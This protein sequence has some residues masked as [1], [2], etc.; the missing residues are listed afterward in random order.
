MWCWF[1][2][3][4]AQQR[5]ASWI[6]LKISSSQSTLSYF[7]PRLEQQHFIAAILDLSKSQVGLEE[8]YK[9]K[10]G[11]HVLWGNVD[12][13]SAI[14]DKPDPPLHDGKTVIILRGKAL[15]QTFSILIY[16]SQVR[17]AFPKNTQSDAFDIQSNFQ[18]WRMQTTETTAIGPLVHKCQNCRKAVKRFQHFRYI[19][20]ANKQ[21]FEIGK[22]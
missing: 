1:C 7:L 17:C 12:M 3:K 2:F 10:L 22:V 21:F 11:R 8:L 6:T 20:S 19:Y 4:T 14:F 13:K 16:K 15:P 18:K 9:D 5:M